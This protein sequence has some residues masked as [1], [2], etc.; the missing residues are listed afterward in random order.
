MYLLLYIITEGFEIG[1][2]HEK[3]IDGTMYI[4]Y[5]ASL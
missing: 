5:E 1:I 2:A 3:F 4:H